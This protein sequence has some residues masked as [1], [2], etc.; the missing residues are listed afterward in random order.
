MSLGQVLTTAMDGLKVAQ[1]GMALIAAN[2][3][4]SST[5]G[6]SEKTQSLQVVTSGG[7]NIGVD[8]AA[9]NRQLDDFVRNQL[10][11][12]SAGGAYADTTTQIYQQLQ[13]AYGDPGS[14]ALLSGSYASF[15][16]AVQNLASNPSDYSAQTG[17]LNA[18]TALAG[19]LNSLT[20]SIQGLRS[21]C[22]QGLSETVSNANGLLQQIANINTQV[23]GMPANAAAA[24]LLD[25]R[26]AAIDQ[27][28][29]LMD[30]RVVPGNGNE[31]D[32]FTSS[33]LQLAGKMASTLSFNSHGTLIA[34]S[35]WN[36]DPTKSGVVTITLT[37]PSGGTT[38]LVATNAIRSGQIGAYLAM[39]D[40]ILPQAQSQLDQVAG[41]MSS[42]LSDYTTNGSPAAAG[43][44]SGFDIGVGN[45]IAGNTVTVSYTVAPGTSRTLTIEE[46][47]DPAALP[48]PSADPNHPVVGI[49]FSG[50][51]AAAVG[52]L[53]ALFTGQ[54]QFS[55]P[56][57]TTL[58]VLDG[59]AGSGV[60]VNAV[61]STTT[62][63]ALAGGT[64]QL[65]LFTDGGTPFS[66][67]ITGG[68]SQTLGYAGRIAVNPALAANPANLVAFQAGTASGDPTRPDFLSTQLTSG[69]L[70]FA[71]SA[72]IGS[73]SAP[74]SGTVSSYINQVL[75]TQ[76]PPPHRQK[77]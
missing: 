15:A 48:L 36:A 24:S 27:L 59:G 49:D 4:N 8:V 34:N 30:I 68:G 3:A 55:N 26:D 14:S 76:A 42:A 56:S 62:Q 28:A 53:N 57:G 64:T 45:L 66:G 10:R 50:G 73:A 46:V 22:E 6:Y 52:Q 37:G 58:R 63:T 39:R 72:G 61:T 11:T 44:Q 21:S 2:V 43:G 69:S 1:S 7:S 38:D 16:G 17:V 77:A 13:Q 29:K 9:V 60:T 5:P 19:Q 41:V 33:G 32:V 40:R 18:A 75:S 20:T 71:P 74:Y 47:K 51:M 25:Q 12:E 54:L 65:P 70:A 31:V 35:Q 23:A 67:A